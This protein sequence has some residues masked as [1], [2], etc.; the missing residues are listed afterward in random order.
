M[1]GIPGR[2]LTGQLPRPIPS[3]S[4]VHDAAVIPGAAPMVVGLPALCH[5]T[6]LPPALPPRD[7][8]LNGGP[9]SSSAPGPSARVRDRTGYKP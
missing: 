4:D 1:A 8:R 7:Q 2:R 5:R 6:S 9:R 3:A